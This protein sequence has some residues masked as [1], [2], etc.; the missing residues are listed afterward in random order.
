MVSSGEVI[1]T[2][3]PMC[4]IYKDVKYITR[5][6]Q[7]SQ[8]Q[9]KTVGIFFHQN[10]TANHTRQHIIHCP[11]QVQHVVPFKGIKAKPV[12]PSK[13]TSNSESPFQKN[14]R[15]STGLNETLSRCG[16]Q[17]LYKTNKQL[18]Y[19]ILIPYIVELCFLLQFV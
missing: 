18:L 4:G 6:S 12:L 5:I 1:Y 11:T 2:I 9:P 13:R 16:S 15:T 10:T 8:G 17:A 3:H 7:L 19:N 14:S